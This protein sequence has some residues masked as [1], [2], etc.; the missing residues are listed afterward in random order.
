MTKN[1]RLQLRQDTACKHQ[2]VDD[3]FSRLDISKRDEYGIFL[4][5]HFIAL[6]A[7]E[8]HF[9][10]VGS[11]FASPPAQSG[12]IH[13]DILALGEKPVIAKLSSLPELSNL[14]GLAYVVSGAHF[15]AAVLLKR[16]SASSDPATLSARTYLQS[17][18]MRSYWPVVVREI[19]NSINTPEDYS[20]LVKG[21]LAAFDLYFDSYKLVEQEKT[22]VQIA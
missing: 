22:F 2:E 6:S 10:E 13:Q 9:A 3:L 14:A 17:A 19:K 4:K 18:D 8:K 12:L 15:G 11:S 20:V 5:A 1:Y 7:I 16:V 21:A